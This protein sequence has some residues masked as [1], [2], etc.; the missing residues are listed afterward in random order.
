MQRMDDLVESRGVE[1]IAELHEKHFEG[2]VEKV[3]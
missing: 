1:V 2:A 3:L